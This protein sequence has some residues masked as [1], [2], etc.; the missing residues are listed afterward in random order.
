MRPCV[1][2][3]LLVCVVSYVAV[4]VAVCVAEC[5][6]VCV[7]VCVAVSIAMCVDLFDSAHLLQRVSQCVLF[8]LVLAPFLY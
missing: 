7:V 2:F 4:C 5:V 8:G 6:A 3:A 1:V